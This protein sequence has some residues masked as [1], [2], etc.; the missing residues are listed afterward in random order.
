VATAAVSLLLAACGDGGPSPEAG[1]TGTPAAPLPRTID[2]AEEQANLTLWA[3]DPGDLTSDLPALAA[4]DFNDDGIEDVLVGVRFGDGRDN[5]RAD[6]GEAYVVFGSRELP[7]TSDAAAGQ[8][9]ITIWGAGQGDNLG[10]A[11]H[12]GDINGD[13]ID[14]ILLGAPFASRAETSQPRIGAVFVFFGSP[15]LASELDIAA[16]AQDLTLWGPSSTS[17]FGDSLA[18]GDLNGDGIQDIII[19]STFAPGQEGRGQAGTV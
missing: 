12:G 1:P 14:D 3:V 6:A 13:G 9:D 19:G 18:S 10:Y 7:S 17:F 16:G 15:D 5:S 11:L 8:Q 2:L 4:G